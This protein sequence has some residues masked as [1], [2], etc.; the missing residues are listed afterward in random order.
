LHFK[1]D[2]IGYLDRRRMHLYVFNLTERK[3][4]QITFGDYDDSEP[5]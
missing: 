1:E 4:R 3:T 2:E 5:A